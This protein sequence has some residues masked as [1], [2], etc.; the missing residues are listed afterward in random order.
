LKSQVRMGEM[1]SWQN[2]GKT[3]THLARKKG[4]GRDR[5]P[6]ISF[7]RYLFGACTLPAGFPPAGRG[8]TSNERKRLT[9]D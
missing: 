5:N 2:Y 6:L 8:A 3:G 4:S 9:E 1:D 7:D